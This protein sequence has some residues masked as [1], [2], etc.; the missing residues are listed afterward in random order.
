MLEECLD[1][2]ELS[3]GIGDVYNG[4]IPALTKYNASWYY[5]LAIFAAKTIRIRIRKGS[6]FFGDID[7]EAIAGSSCAILI[8]EANGE[9]AS[10]DCAV[11]ADVKVVSNHVICLGSKVA[12]LYGCGRAAW[13][14]AWIACIF[15]EDDLLRLGGALG[16]A[17]RKLVAI[18]VFLQVGIGGT[19]E[20]AGLAGSVVGANGLKAEQTAALTAGIAAIEILSLFTG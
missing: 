3:A 19:A 9:A 6:N 8:K 10:V 1:Y 5:C 20:V 15:N 7:S 17:D 13:A 12:D 4:I 2:L 18:G 11:E 14:S 16:Q